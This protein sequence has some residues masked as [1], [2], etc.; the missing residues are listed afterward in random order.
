MKQFL[1]CDFQTIWDFK[2]F[3]HLS[4][5]SQLIG[6]CYI[7]LQINILPPPKYCSNLGFITYLTFSLFLIPL[8]NSDLPPKIILLLCKI[9]PLKFPLVGF[10]WWHTLSFVSVSVLILNSSLKDFFPLKTLGWQV[11]SSNIEDAILLGSGPQVLVRG[12]LSLQ[13]K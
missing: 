7:I 3:T 9:Q 10:S 6:Y 11:F 2:S 12:H 13:R 1:F 8:H 5:S 4:H